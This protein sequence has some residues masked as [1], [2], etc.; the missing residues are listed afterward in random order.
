[1]Y[2]CGNNLR[3]SNTYFYPINAGVK[4][5]HLKASAYRIVV[6]QGIDSSS[7]LKY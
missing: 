7:L 5:N 4:V 1:M 3:L 2:K 6:L